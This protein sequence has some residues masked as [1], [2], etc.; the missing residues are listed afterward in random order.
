MEKDGFL[1]FQSE[2]KQVLAETS[3][4]FMAVIFGRAVF[5]GA[6]SLSTAALIFSLLI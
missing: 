4:S 5:N 2:Q 1:F 3:R 6:P